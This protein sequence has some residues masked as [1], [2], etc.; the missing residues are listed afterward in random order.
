M[1]GAPSG[2]GISDTL[3]TGSFTLAL[4]VVKGIR[5]EEGQSN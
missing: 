3:L 4:L 1:K 2:I 5:T